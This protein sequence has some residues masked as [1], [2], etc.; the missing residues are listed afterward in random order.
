VSCARLLADLPDPSACL[1]GRAALRSSRRSAGVGAHYVAGSNTLAALLLITVRGMGALGKAGH[2]RSFMR[3][4]AQS[5]MAFYAGL[6][7]A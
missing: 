3:G 7:T 6:P 1:D 4:V 5:S 2:S